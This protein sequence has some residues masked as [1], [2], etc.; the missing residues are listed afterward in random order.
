MQQNPN[1][2][3]TILASIGLAILLKAG[4][5]VPLMTS[6]VALGIIYLARVVA[7][8]MRPGLDTAKGWLKFMGNTLL[9][10]VTFLALRLIATS[11]LGL[12][13]AQTYQKLED[14]GGLYWTLFG[15]DVSN[16]ILWEIL[17]AILAGGLV[18]AWIR[19]RGGKLVMAIF[20][21]A[22]LVVTLQ[23]R[24]P[25]SAEAVSAESAG[26][27]TK[28]ETRI[29]EKGA[30]GAI[31]PDVGASSG[32]WR[33]IQAVPDQERAV[34]LP[35][36]HWFDLNPEAVVVVRNENGD[37]FLWKPDDTVFRHAGDCKEGEQVEGIRDIPK[38]ILYLRACD[39]RIVRVGITVEPATMQAYQ[40]TR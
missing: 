18:V 20:V 11:F 6:F 23:V 17:F 21:I 31:L 8:E 19:G 33:N 37:E 14:S 32:E 15:A 4:F 29:K 38:S 34:K 35:Y 39:N 36:L 25:K 5:A 9:G 12:P 24:F 7:T 2:I 13:L 40:S 1:W 22:F 3:R 30:F 10:V 27:D 26:W 16:V 28:L